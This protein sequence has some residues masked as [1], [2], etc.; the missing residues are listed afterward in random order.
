MGYLL[1]GRNERSELK[2][3]NS[4]N[5]AITWDEAFEA[6]NRLPGPIK[7][8][9]RRSTVDLMLEEDCEEIGSSD[10]NHRMFDLY[11]T[12]NNSWQAVIAY[13]LDYKV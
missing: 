11:K 6:F 4:M 13:F 10:V 8:S 12:N 1:S 9:I 2:Y 3:N 7:Y 5:T